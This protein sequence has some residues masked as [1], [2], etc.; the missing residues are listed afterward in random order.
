MFSVA[1]RH[2]L[3]SRTYSTQPCDKLTSFDVTRRINNTSSGASSSYVDANIVI[4]VWVEVIMRTHL[5]S[6]FKS[7]TQQKSSVYGEEK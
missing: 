6:A 7:N 4:D 5:V 1:T 3:V 2:A